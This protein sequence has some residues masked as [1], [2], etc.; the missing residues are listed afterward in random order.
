MRTPFLRCSIWRDEVG[1]PK[2]TP[3]PIIEQLNSAIN[4][5]LQQSP[6]KQRLA[7]LGAEGFVTSP[8]SFG[9]YIADYT[10]TWASVIREAGIKL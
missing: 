9:K 3:T 10:Q 8:A 1:A 6:L 2:N 5:G 7:E 4:A